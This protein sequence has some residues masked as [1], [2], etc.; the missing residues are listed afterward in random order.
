MTI[1]PRA[2]A[3][4]LIRRPASQVFEAFVD[5]E[6]TSK[7][8]FTGGSGRLE[9][10]KTVTWE[11]AMYGFSTAVNV[12]AL[13]E[14]RRILVEWPGEE[15][16]LTQVEWVFTDRGDGT[17]FVSI[18]HSGFSGE[19]AQ[20]AEQAVG[21]TEGFAFVLAG[22]KAYLERGVQLN[23]VADRFPDGLGA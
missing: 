17:T 15:D 11:W 16:N 18:T 13:E 4:M 6:I 20:R 14:D 10:G 19:D 2:R 12:K 8:W 3:E 21:S 7:F 23:L 22:L 1:N 9:P 5:P